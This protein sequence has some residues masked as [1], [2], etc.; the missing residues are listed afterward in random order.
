MENIP[1]I[2]KGEREKGLSKFSSFN[3]PR[4]K[5]SYTSKVLIGLLFISALALG[6]LYA[7]KFSLDKKSENLDLELQ[8]IVEQRD[9]DFERRLKNLGALMEA[10]KSILDDHHYWTLF[11]KL[12]EEKTLS[13]ITFKSF[14]GDDDSSTVMITGSSPSYG[15]LAKQVKIFE[16]TPGVVSAHASGIALS[17]KGK[18]D[19][20]IQIV[21]SKETI[22]KK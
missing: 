10:F 11:F 16:D 3:R 6:G 5:F 7:F 4:F 13:T 22:R 9:M 15:E 2:S 18:V 17:E 1:L 21:F 20:S 12:L 19:F 8:Q 14:Q